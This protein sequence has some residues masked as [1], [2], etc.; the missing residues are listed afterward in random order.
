MLYALC[1]PMPYLCSVWISTQFHLCRLVSACFVHVVS[2]QGKHMRLI[3]SLFSPP[4]LP[5]PLCTLSRP[6]ASRH[7][8]SPSSGSSSLAPDYSTPRKFRWE[9]CRAISPYYY[10]IRAFPGNFTW[11]QAVL[12]RKNNNQM[13]VIVPFFAQPED[14]CNSGRLLSLSV[15]PLGR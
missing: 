7:D 3:H 13:Q 10:S 2:K 11:L 15:R 5:P 12:H 8:A 9:F 1:F 6:S 14:N 4:P